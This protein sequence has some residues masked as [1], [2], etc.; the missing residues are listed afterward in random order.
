MHIDELRKLYNNQCLIV[1]Q[2]CINRMMERGIELTEIKQAIATGEIIEDYP[3][4]YP[5]PSALILGCGLHVVA[6][7]GDGKL[8][9]ITA[10]RPDPSQWDDDLKKRR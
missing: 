1:T 8:W 4:D 3:D 9:L 5:Y 7:I 2:H 6:G 10:Y